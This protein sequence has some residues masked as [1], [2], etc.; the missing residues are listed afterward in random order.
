MTTVRDTSRNKQIRQ[1]IG[2]VQLLATNF[3][4]RVRSLGKISVDQTVPDYAFWDR[5]RRGAAEGYKLAG[6]FVR[7]VTQTLSSFVLGEGIQAALNLPK[8]RLADAE[9]TDG[10]LGRLMGQIH[11]LL[12]TLLEDHY[13]LGDQYIVV[14]PDTSFSIPSPDTVSVEYDAVDYRKITRA[15]IRTELPNV[16]V[17]DVYT[18]SERVI[19]VEYRAKSGSPA[20][21]ETQ[22]FANLIGRIPIVHF[23]NDRSGNETNGRPIVEALLPLL[24]HYDT[25]LQ[26]ALTGASVMGTPYPVIEGVEDLDS[27]FDMFSQG[28]GEMYE[29]TYGNSQERKT[30]NIDPTPG[31][32][33]GKGASFKFAAPPSGFTGDARNMLKSLF[34]LL[35]DFTR[36]PEALWGGAIS[37][38]KAS[39]EVQMPPFYQYV[40]LLRTKF[41]GSAADELLSTSA[42]GGLHE[43]IDIWLKMRR[44]VDP[45]VVVAPITFTF[46]SLLAEDK[47]NKREWADKLYA[48]GL[49]SGETYLKLSELI[50][51]PASELAAAEA[52]AQAR[53]AAFEEQSASGQIS[54]L[55]RDELQ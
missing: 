22:V 21:S 55:A 1:M 25:V 43:L 54:R 46:P 17:T 3:W 49:I 36:M 18:E 30:V 5:L 27:A 7:P 20:R 47:V 37:S 15:T 38:S 32:L 33:L 4:M 26:N 16:I 31:L 10:L 8:D 35:L 40:E 53:Q 12:Q 14:N 29:D 44:L 41:A 23:A 51:D 19:T 11:S 13:A 9:Y 52:E 24:A 2:R 42:H 6:L 48:A 45:Q 34:L 39:A 50:D 28:T